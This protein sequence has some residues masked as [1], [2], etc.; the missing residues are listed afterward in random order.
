MCWHLLRASFL[1]GQ[2]QA[3]LE[4]CSV[5]QEAATLKENE[6]KLARIHKQAEQLMKR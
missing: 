6:A 2:I 3:K 1:P 5:E 4:N